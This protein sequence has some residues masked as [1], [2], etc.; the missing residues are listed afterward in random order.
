M[1]G[2]DFVKCAACVVKPDA[3]PAACGHGA[4]EE[5]DKLVNALKDLS[6][7]VKLASDKA[8]QKQKKTPIVN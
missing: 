5:Q 3:V 8:S 4:K 2:N 7:N 6:A 1:N